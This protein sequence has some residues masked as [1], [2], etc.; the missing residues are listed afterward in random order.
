[1]SLQT[2]LS[3]MIV[4]YIPMLYI[5]IQCV[6]ELYTLLLNKLFFL[7]LR[8]NGSSGN[9]TMEG[10]GVEACQ[11]VRKAPQMQCDPLW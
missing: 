6:N 3:V 11:Q 4:F 10:S 2:V 9:Y 1:M 7:E 5:M 8:R